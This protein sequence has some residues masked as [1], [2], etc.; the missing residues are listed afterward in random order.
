MSLPLKHQRLVS[1]LILCQE[2]HPADRDHVARYFGPYRLPGTSSIGLRK[3]RPDLFQDANNSQRETYPDWVG[4]TVRR[5]VRHLT[6]HL[7]VGLRSV[8]EK[9]DIDLLTDQIMTILEY[10]TMEGFP[11]HEA[12][13]QQMYEDIFIR[14]VLS[15]IHPDHGVCPL[16]LYR[17]FNALC[18]RLG[19]VLIDE[20]KSQQQGRYGAAIDDLIRVAVLSGHVGTNLKSTASAASALLNRDRIPIQMAWIRD[21]KTVNSLSEYELR[22]SAKALIDLSRGPEGRF[23]LDCLSTYRQEVMETDEPTLL[24]FFSDDYLESMIDMKRLEIV[25][26]SNSNLTVLFVP[27]SGRY[28]NDLAL[29]DMAG[30]VR[31]RRFKRFRIL[32]K[33]GRIVISPYG[34]KAGCIDPRDI[35][36]T[37]MES[38]DSLGKGRRV[39]LETKGCRNFE[40]LKGDLPI[41]WYASF[42]C[43]RA[44]SIRTVGI[45]GPP[46]FLRIPPGLL[47]YDGFTRPRIAPSPSYGTSGVRF[48]RMT[49]RQLC[50]SL[51]SPVYKEL[52]VHASDE[53]YLNSRLQAQAAT[54]K[55]T[56]SEL[57][58]ETK[59]DKRP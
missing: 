7:S 13:P 59:H 35:S 32:V 56:F 8:M 49:T 47:A 37:L 36:A 15:I 38:F 21:M 2:P 40:M 50:E 25:A 14:M 52:L 45:D 10:E 42:N 5:T 28:G 20:L 44:L 57:M 12:I 54:L 58:A 30:L 51:K 34:P 26:D 11:L 29:A 9:T 17:E 3:N 22:D 4:Q 23:A 53:R 39:I 55:I 24:V 41:P 48:A 46:V 19:L 6:P 16:H 31:D 43:N 1:Q 27:R 33:M 18:H